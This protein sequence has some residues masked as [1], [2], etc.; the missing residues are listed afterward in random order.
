MCKPPSKDTAEGLSLWEAGSRSGE[1]GGVKST[2]EAEGSG[3]SAVGG[4]QPWW[5][6]ASLKI[7]KSL[8]KVQSR[9]ERLLFS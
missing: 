3:W 7:N 5:E 6:D 4:P 2:E 9:R 8:G 1:T